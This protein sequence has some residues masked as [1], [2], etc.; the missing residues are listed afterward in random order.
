TDEDLVAGKDPQLD[1]AIEVLK[2]EMAGKK[3]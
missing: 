1:K 3:Y 2:E